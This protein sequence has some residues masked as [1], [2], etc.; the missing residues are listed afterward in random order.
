MT[1]TIPHQLKGIDR[2]FGRKHN[3]DGENLERKDQ[4][5]SQKPSENK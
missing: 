1:L 2:K 3:L 5:S 4:L